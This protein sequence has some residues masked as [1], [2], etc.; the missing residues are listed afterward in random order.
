MKT[1]PSALL[2]TGWPEVFAFLLQVFIVFQIIQY[3]GKKI[4]LVKSGPT[5]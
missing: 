5:K 2:W 3:L 4:G 1:E